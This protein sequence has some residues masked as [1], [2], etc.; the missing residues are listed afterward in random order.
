M[1]STLVIVVEERSKQH[2]LEAFLRTWRLDPAPDIKFFVANG[3]SDLTRQL[4]TL[5]RAWRKPR[6]RFLVLCDQDSADCVERKQELIA[7]VP[8]SR[9]NDVTVRIVCT[10]LEGWYLADRTAL[11]EALP[12]FPQRAPPPPELRG[13]PDSIQRPASR[14]RRYAP[15]SKRDLA[16]E[17]GRRM[18]PN[19]GSASSSFNLFIRTLDELFQRSAD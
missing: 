10:E 5:M 18:L 14:I 19:R 9:R 1:N 7:Q 15:F 12:Q 6:T 16:R 3:H 4:Y 13:P 11:R 2:F 17:M 8:C